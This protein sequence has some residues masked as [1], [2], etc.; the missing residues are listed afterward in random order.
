MAE[1]KN[2]MIGFALITLVVVATMY[3]VMEV[4]NTYEITDTN[5]GAFELAQFNQSMYTINTS[6]YQIYKAIEPSKNP[7]ADILEGL[8]IFT[9]LKNLAS[10]LLIKPIGLIFG[11]ITGVLG[12]PSWVL[13]IISATFLI[14]IIFGI[15]KLLKVGE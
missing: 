6:A 13:V 4:G 2:L 11:M 14:A 12:F 5:F 9:P 3:A 1:I 10:E 8:S 15:I 7:I